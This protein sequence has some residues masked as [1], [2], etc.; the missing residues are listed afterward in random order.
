[1][2][3]V[4]NRPEPVNIVHRPL[5]IWHE[6]F[7]Y[8]RRHRPTPK[9][10]RGATPG[11]RSD[12]KHRQLAHQVGGVSTIQASSMA[13]T[14]DSKITLR[15]GSVFCFGTISSIADEEGTLHRI[16]NPP[17]K[18][19]PPTNSENTGEAQPPAF[20]RKIAFRKSGAEGPLTRRTPLST[21]STKEWTQVAKKKEAGRRQ[22]VLSVPPPSKENGKKSSR[23]PYHSTPTSSSSGEWSRLPSPTMSR[24]RPEKNHLSENPADGETGAGIFDDIMRPENGI[25]S[26]LFRGT[27]SRR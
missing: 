10:P 15:P 2:L 20:R 9:T 12:P 11:V 23:P 17:K 25:R 16:A 24:P 21:S 26:N 6:P 19:S 27:R 1:V 7:C 22:A 5:C 4:S 18:K 8:S 14:F 3:R 13:V